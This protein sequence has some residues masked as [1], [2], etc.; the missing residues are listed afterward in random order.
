MELWRYGSGE[1][2][3]LIAKRS[4]SCREVVRAHLDRIDAVNAQVNA[5]TVVLA[6]EALAMA[7]H[8]DRQPA[9]NL[10]PN[11]LYGVP[12]P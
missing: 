1:L 7:E 10:G 6:E 11:P 2:G 9:K 3:A 5:L 4:A 8:L 12:V